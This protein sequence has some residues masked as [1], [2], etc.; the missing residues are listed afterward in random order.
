DDAIPENEDADG[1]QKTS[2]K[3]QV[4]FDFFGFSVLETQLKPYHNPTKLNRGFLFPLNF[5]L[6]LISISSPPPE[7]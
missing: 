3:K 1:D 6:P 5:E 2:T 7:Y 4:A